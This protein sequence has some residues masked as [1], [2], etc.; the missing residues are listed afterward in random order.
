MEGHHVRIFRCHDVMG[1][2]VRRMNLLTWGRD[3]VRLWLD[4]RRFYAFEEEWCIDAPLAAVWKGMVHVEGWPDWWEGLLLADSQDTLPAGMAGK[5][6]RTCWKGALPYRLNVDARIRDVC[7]ET[8]ILADID[9]DIEGVC[10]CRIEESSWGTRIFFSLHVRTNRFWMSVFSLF[11]KG[12][13]S[14]NH[15]RI[16]ARGT[17]GFMRCLAKGAAI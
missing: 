12:Y 4:R 6:Y 14:E 15:Q 17:R 7:Q 5:C 2:M 8:F 16:M 10:A 11:F 1:F 3:T 13:L 9:G